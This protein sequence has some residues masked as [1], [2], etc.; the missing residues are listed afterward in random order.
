MN[1]I[2]CV[3]TGRFPVLECRRSVVMPTGFEH[4]LPPYFPN[5]QKHYQ[6]SSDGKLL[7]RLL[8][9]LVC[10][11]ITAFRPV[12]AQESPLLLVT[13]PFEPFIFPQEATLKGMDYEIV[14][15]V[16]KNL[17]LPIKVEYYPWNRCL[18]M[19]QNRKADAL[20]DLVI[21]EERKSYIFFPQEPLSSASL[22]VFYARGNRP[23][24]KKLEDLKS[25][26]LGAQL[27]SEYPRELNE[28]LVRREDTASI[29]QNFQKLV[30]GRVD[31]LIENRIVGR[32]TANTLGL[33]DRVGVMELPVVF[34][35]RYYLGF[36]HKEGH[37]ALAEKFSKALVEFKRTPAYRDIL[38]KY[39]QVE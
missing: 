14:E 1:E 10:I 9:I 36:S 13:D 31:I 23:E 28:V 4:I 38:T 24:I 20:I 2:R 25:L 33:Q 16:F 22:V 7:K 32:Y 18:L 15:S 11:L 19:I 35:S 21:S 5:Q 17:E 27:G 29:A 30:R 34:S 8:S 37:K 3:S 6:Y 39:G 26:L 12:S